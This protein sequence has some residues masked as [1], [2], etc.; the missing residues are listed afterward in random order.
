MLLIKGGLIHNA[1]SPEPFVG[2]ILVAEGKIA[3]IAPHIEASDAEVY[4]ASGREIYPGFVEAHG[5]IGLDGYGIGFEGQDYNEYGDVMTPQLRAIDGIEPRD[6]ALAEARS[7][8]VTTLCVGPGS[9]NVLGGTFTAIKPVGVRVEHMVVK[10]EVAM[11]CAFGENPKRCYR[12]KGNCSRMTTAAHLREMLFKAREYMNKLDAAKDDPSKAPAFDM[13]LNAL[14][15]VLRGEM[16]LKA[17]AHQ[18]NDF[19]TALRIAHEFG[20]KITLEHVTEGHLVADE[21][22]KENV[23]LA[24]G[25]TLGHASKFELRNKSWSTPGVLAA[26]GC[27]VS[28][29]TDSPVIPEKY[30]PICA[31]LAVKAGMDPF[32]ALKAVTINPAEHIGLADRIGSLEEGKDA[33]IVIAD[34]SPFSIETQILD[35]FIDGRKTEKFIEQAI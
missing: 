25:P 33:D 15:P 9:S 1:V 3:K 23:M 22:A 27:H 24:I 21:L 17:H 4:D 20:V 18:T 14:V 29:I 12:D 10:A 13:K 6:R 8:G 31:G 28:I 5:H 11:K 35:V 2:D 26:S 19:F 32:E 7:A 16:P 34:G 30:L